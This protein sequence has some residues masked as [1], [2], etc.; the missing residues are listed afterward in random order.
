M[1]SALLT[2]LVEEIVTALNT[3]PGS[4]WSDYTV[5]TAVDDFVK[6]VPCLDPET[7]F[8]SDH[9]GLF[10]CPM[11]MD[12]NR[13]ASKGRQRIVSLNRKPVIAMCLTYRFESP[14]PSGLDLAPW[15]TVKKLLNLREEIEL[16]L[17]GSQYTV[18]LL[19]ITAEPVQEL[20]MKSRWF[21]A[22]TEFE[23]E[24]MACV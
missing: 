5:G 9:K 22:V 12:Y 10:I 8:E 1:A 21:L 2:T 13:D 16:F 17:I 6:A 11:V 19:T 14:D 3:A 23:F 7:M 20:P 15:D 4:T 24:S 18:N